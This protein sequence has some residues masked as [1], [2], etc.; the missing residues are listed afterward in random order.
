MRQR[1]TLWQW[2][3]GLAGRKGPK[4]ALL[5]GAVLVIGAVA[6][7]WVQ[8]LRRPPD[9]VPRPLPLE[10]GEE[11]VVWLYPATNTDAWRLFVQAV[12]QVGQQLQLTVEGTPFPEETTTVPSVGLVLARPDQPTRRLL[13]RWYKLTSHWE[14]SDWVRALVAGPR[15][16]PFAIVGGSNSNRA[17]ELALALQE[18][19]TRA[20]LPPSRCPLLL[21][22]RATADQVEIADENT[23]AGQPRQI[24]LHEI[25]PNRTFRSCFTNRQMADTVIRFIWSRADL[26]PNRGPV[27][28][29]SW[30]DDT[31]SQDL[32]TGFNQAVQTRVREDQVG[33]GGRW[34]ATAWAPP[35]WAP[36]WWQLFSL[37][38]AYDYGQ[39]WRLPDFLQLP[40]DSSVGAPFLV[41]QFE[42][43]AVQFL[44]DEVADDS[45]PLTGVPA[46]DDPAP[47]PRRLLLMGGGIQPTR[48]FLQAVAGSAPGQARHFVVA[49]GDI[50]S[51]N[52]IYRDRQVSWPIQQLPFV[53][54]F[55]CHFN[56]VDPQAGF[57]P[58]DGAGD[59]QHLFQEM[60]GEEDRTIRDPW[61]EAMATTGTEEI[62]LYR[63]IVRA[64]AR[65]RLSGDQQASADLD[66]QDL[67]AR[68]EG[69]LF[70]SAGIRRPGSGEHVV[71][72][73]PVFQGP[74]RD[75]VLPR[76]LIE[77]WAV[78]REGRPWD[79]VQKLEVRYG[80][81]PT[82]W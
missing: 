81:V 50:V 76:A 59:W 20:S 11:E 65:S 14:T 31:Y 69:E 13:F 74:D 19:T 67:L 15:A 64:L 79:C 73:R 66:P 16:P 51:F 75:R 39:H 21:L 52:T 10:E 82:S 5:I 3:R 38:R 77:V 42:E 37:N 36:P 44:L 55:F 6:Y 62:L 7:L 27:Y 35:G 18:E 58:L 70:T 17:R 46:L 45:S 57:R 47:S 29:V 43:H 9:P 78:G 28:A 48:R 56:P 4:V 26:R 30:K 1:G 60:P 12:E 33:K 53:L 32:V 63:E 71:C 80:D 25:Y 23:G 41:N 8:S 72:V 24:D 34:T 22:T 2:V 40:I 68:T 49:T 61:A 54:V